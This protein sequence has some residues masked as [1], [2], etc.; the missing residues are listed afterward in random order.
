MD[1]EVQVN[2]MKSSKT[3]EIKLVNINPNIC[4]RY[5]DQ[6]SFRDALSRVIDPHYNCHNKISISYGVSNNFFIY[7]PNNYIIGNVK[8]I[9]FDNNKCVII[10]TNKDYIKHIESKGVENFRIGFC[11]RTNT[12]N[13]YIGD[14]G[15]K[16]YNIDMICYFVLHNN[17]AALSVVGLL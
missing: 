2:N 11:S 1:V 14:D 17:D 15:N 8:S 9:D 12:E 16:Y 6:K 7:P 4:E 3:F 5:Y 13:C 10:I